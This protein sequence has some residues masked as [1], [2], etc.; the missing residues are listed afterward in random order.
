MKTEDYV[1]WLRKMVRTGR[2]SITEAWMLLTLRSTP[3]GIRTDYLAARMRMQERRVKQI[4]AILEEKG[5]IRRQITGYDN[6]PV[7]E[8][9]VRRPR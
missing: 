6:G 4:L 8:I 3:K 5:L 9:T 7:R 2:V 1:S